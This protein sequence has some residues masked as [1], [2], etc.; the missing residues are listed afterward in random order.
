[1]GFSP[2]DALRVQ[3]GGVVPGRN[4]EEKKTEKWK[5]TTL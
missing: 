5:Y 1:M 3:E 4:D 2:V